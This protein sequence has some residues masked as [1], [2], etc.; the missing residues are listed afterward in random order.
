M[1]RPT[2][3]SGLPPAAFLFSPWAVA[4]SD[5]LFYLASGS[6]GERRHPTQAPDPTGP[7]HLASAD[8]HQSGTGLL[9]AANRDH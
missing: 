1:K 4:M 7:T 9:R 5:L 2:R 6:Q 8:Q 3:R